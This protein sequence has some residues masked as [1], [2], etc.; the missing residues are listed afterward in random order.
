MQIASTTQLLL[1][2]LFVEM[3]Y[4]MVYLECIFRVLHQ[5]WHPFDRNRDRKSNSVKFLSRSDLSNVMPPDQRRGLKI[6]F[7]N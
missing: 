7:F 2:S 3:F 4:S 1:P 6:V 5:L